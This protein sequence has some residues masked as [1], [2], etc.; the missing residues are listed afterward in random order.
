MKISG[1]TT[2]YNCIEMDYPLGL[3]LNSLFSFCDEVCIADGGSNDGTLDFIREHFPKAKLKVTPIDF[4]EAR[5]AIHAD[6]NLKNKARNLCSGDVLWHADN[7]EIVDERH[8]SE[9]RR[10]CEIF[11]NTG[12]SK[13]GMVNFREFW[14]GLNKLRADVK[15]RPAV[16]L[17]AANL[18]IGI[19]HY[20]LGID[21][22]GEK[23]CKP[24]KSDSCQYLTE[25]GS[26]AGF[27]SLSNTPLQ[28]WHLSW[29]DF[30]R[31]I[32]HYRDFWHAFHASMYNLKLEDSP[33]NNV[34][35]DKKWSDVKNEDIQEMSATLDRLGPRSFHEKQRKWTGPVEY[36]NKNAI[37]N[38]IINWASERGIEYEN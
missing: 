21:E 17:A 10:V 4:S 28:I 36:I 20:A 12:L 1:Y 11:K 27:A 32:S 22:D 15:L 23:F 5:W 14:G 33:Q 2:T 26:T 24:F 30:K 9:A 18:Q 37:P 13:V 29:L 34:M 38:S 35:F 25:N 16:S 7:D 31:K 19:P 8:Y 6:G 3:C